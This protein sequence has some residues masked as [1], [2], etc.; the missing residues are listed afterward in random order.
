MNPA[1]TFGPAVL[2]MNFTD[3]WVSEIK[4]TNCVYTANLYSVKVA[5][6]AP[7]LKWDITLTTMF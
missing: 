2:A 5:A 1:R 4:K 3:H 7:I 6:I